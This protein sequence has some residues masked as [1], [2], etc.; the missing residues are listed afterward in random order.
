MITVYPKEYFSI[1]ILFARR[2]AEIEDVPFEEAIQDYTNIAKDLLNI[3]KYPPNKESRWKKLFDITNISDISN[4][5]NLWYEHYK[6]LPHSK[7]EPV[8]NKD[9]KYGMFSYSLYPNNTTINIHAGNVKR[10]QK[11]S[12]FS[13]ICY[14]E[15][16]KDLYELITDVYNK[17]PDITKVRCSSWINNIPSYVALFPEEYKNSLRIKDSNNFLGI[18]QQ[19]L[20]KNGGIKTD[21]MENF[22]Q[23]IGNAEDI[24]DLKDSFPYKVLLG[25]IGINCFDI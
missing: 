12:S 15:N 24:K 2:I 18:W 11:Y 4:I 8:Q 14:N 5:P 17:Y 13:S 25:E 6:T 23:K 22:T 21:L 7:W 9:L 16:K 19:F 3:S 1:Q 10:G 20:D